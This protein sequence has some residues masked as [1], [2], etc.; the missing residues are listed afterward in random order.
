MPLEARGTMR[1]DP[2]VG[3]S[4]AMVA[5][6]SRLR[7]ALPSFRETRALFPYTA[8][9]RGRALRVLDTGLAAHGLT[10]SFEAAGRPVV[11]LG[12]NAPPNWLARL[13]GLGSARVFFPSL[14][15]LMGRRS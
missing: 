3:R 11:L 14:S 13:M 7:I 9:L 1:L 6:G 5:E 2:P 15:W 10:L 4:L 8:G 12:H